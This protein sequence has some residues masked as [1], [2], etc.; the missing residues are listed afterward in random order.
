MRPRKP[1]ALHAGSR[2]AGFAPASPA[3]GIR[4]QAGLAELRRLGFVVQSPTTVATEG[5][6]AASTE[7]RRDELARLCAE[8]AVDS[9]IALRGGYGSNYLLDGFATDDLTSPKC[10]VGFSDIT[11]IQI[12]LWR[13]AR[14]VSFY[15]PM[16][17]SGLDAGAGAAG[18]YDEP[19]FLR[20]LTETQ[21][22]WPLELSGEAMAAG[23]AEGRVLGGCLTLLETSLGTPWEL[24]T[25][26]SILVL[27]DRAM[28]PWQVDRAL[29]HFRQAGKLDGVR[30][31]L[32]GDF[33]DCDP[34]VAGS[35]SVAMESRKQA[36]SRPSPPLPRP[37][38]GS[39]SS[40][41]SQSIPF[42][43]AAFCAMGS[44]RRLVTLFASDRPMRNS[45]ER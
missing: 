22:G 2:V 24:N 33:P 26:E 38:S 19:S 40:S 41:S 27:E 16:V 3:G 31:I 7:K 23:E 30:G 32:L 45:I 10:L 6:F 21:A 44:T 4:T 8:P 39:C 12:F 13:Q 28:K 36:A 14:W 1:R 37:A 25:E 43:C 18:G 20:A 34:P 9:L 42:I 29:M 11:T 5:Y 35:W 15:G 17:A